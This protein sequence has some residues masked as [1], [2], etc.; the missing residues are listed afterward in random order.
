MVTFNTL[1]NVR[2]LTRGSIRQRISELRSTAVIRKSLPVANL[3]KKGFLFPALSDEE[4][5]KL[6][7]AW[8][9]W[10]TSNSSDSGVPQQINLRKYAENGVLRLAPS[11]PETTGYILCTLIFGLR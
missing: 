10:A 7:L 9:E 6:I 1:I 8:L 5:V 2:P 11:Y 4:H 3:V